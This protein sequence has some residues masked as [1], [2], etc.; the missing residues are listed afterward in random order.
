MG[1]NTQGT[2]D[3][4]RR[5]AVRRQRA[6]AT[7]GRAG[8]RL[9]EVEHDVRATVA[10]QQVVV[11][12]GGQRLGGPGADGERDGRLGGDLERR[13]PAPSPMRAQ[14]TAARDPDSWG[15]TVRSWSASTVRENQPGRAAW[16]LSG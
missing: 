9:R 14:R 16:P 1:V 8:T 4:A 6:G 10:A 7:G 3:A 5:E 2:L 12:D 15:R 13:V 11:V